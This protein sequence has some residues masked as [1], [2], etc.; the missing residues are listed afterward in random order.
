MK[1]GS[2]WS[3]AKVFQPIEALKRPDTDSPRPHSQT[4]AD[5]TLTPI[6]QF[7]RKP[8]FHHAGQCAPKGCLAAEA[9]RSAYRHYIQAGH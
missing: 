8:S 4:T 9:H 3:R 7:R 5:N 6:E 2:L 1:Q